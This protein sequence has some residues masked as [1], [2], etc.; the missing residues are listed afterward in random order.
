METVPTIVDRADARATEGSF[1]RRS[2]A[3]LPSVPLAGWVALFVGVPGGLVVAYSFMT[4]FNF[5]VGPPF[6]L[7]N[8]R[9]LLDSASYL[10]LLLKTF[11]IAGVVTVVSLAAASPFAYYLARVLG[12][13][14]AAML[15]LLTVLPL[16]MNV[17][18]RNYAW[19]SV[20][21]RKG[22]LFSVLES[23]GLEVEL[24]Y[25][26]SLVIV[27]G[28]SLAFPF[29]VL[30]LYARMVNISHEVEEASLDLGS[31][32]LATFMKVIF[33]LSASGYQTAA[34][35]IFMPTLAFFVT[36]LM[37]GGRSGAMI[38]V[39][40][41]PIVKDALDFAG[42]SAFVIP[43]IITLILAVVLLRRG[44]NI[45]NLYRGGVGSGIA[46]RAPR[47]SRGLAI[48]AV[49][50]LVF[51]YLPMLSM[52]LFSFGNN[53]Y[54]IFPMNGMSLKWYEELLRNDAMVVAVRKSIIVALEVAI[55]APIL[56]APAAYAIVRYRFPGR[57][58]FLFV[59]L[60]PILIPELILGMSL[61][62]LLT[63]LDVPLSLQTIVL[64]H[65]TM[66]IPY[67]F[68]TILAQQYGYDR[69]IEEASRDLGAT[70]LGTFMK[71]VLP[72]MVP[73]ILAAA[74]LAITI[75]FNEFVI[76]F[77]LTGGDTTL[78]LYIFGLTKTGI[79]PTA[80]AL[81]A[82]LVVLVIVVVGVVVARPW[83]IALKGYHRAR[84]VFSPGG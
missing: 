79:P 76:A 38:G 54:A 77:M 10:K 69:V 22:V 34:L 82:I 59:S 3:G 65:V 25:T 41:M 9:D 26:M 45:E 83:I 35:L 17:V 39:A 73:G 18:V 12:Q 2:V 46:R 24:L 50:V 64:G 47:K 84:L 61:L 16:W 72:L 81:G 19:M 71:I 62:T 33:P 63:T 21:Q 29:A 1:A 55:I 28:I 75:S 80:N 42:G 27:V 60:L 53:Q 23:V 6:T 36:P 30:V 68:L 37:L 67:V 57:G 8:Y 15:L 32:R 43:V 48:Y 49:G 11:M 66:A 31:G 4:Y 74:F 5:E 58:M 40:L 51:T 14:A 20:V 78:P 44:V 56:C 7:D 52:I 70:P 13:R